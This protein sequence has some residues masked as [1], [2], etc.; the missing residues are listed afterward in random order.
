MNKKMNIFAGIIYSGFFIS[1]VLLFVKTSL[2]ILLWI[3]V[4]Y[5]IDYRNRKYP[6]EYIEFQ[7]EINKNAGIKNSPKI[8]NFNLL[9]KIIVTVVLLFF[10]LCFFAIES[11]KPNY[12]IAYTSRDLTVG[13]QNY[14]KYDQI[15]VDLNS[16]DEKTIRVNANG[17][18]I[19]RTELTN[20]VFVNTPEYTKLK[21]EQKQ[22][23]IKQEQINAEAQKLKNELEKEIEEKVSKI[24][25][26][27]NLNNNSEH[28]FYINPATWVLLAF[29]QKENAFNYAVLYSSIKCNEKETTAKVYTKIRNAS[30]KEVLAEYSIINGIK[31]K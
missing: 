12:E 15:K 18:D 20:I 27:I 28:S 13:K 29:D 16:K 3:I 2:S 1:I 17:K 23:Q 4:F 30:N 26:Q 14:K 25:Y 24:F 6:Q 31:L 11:Y 22:E 21:D 9:T 7:T 8:I 19:E 5:V 10:F